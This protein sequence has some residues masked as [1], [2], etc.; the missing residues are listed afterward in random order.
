MSAT[1]SIS[2][3]LLADVRVAMQLSIDFANTGKGVRHGNNAYTPHAFPAYVAAVAS[4]EAFVNETF[5]GSFCRATYPK[6]SLWDLE[7]G[8]LERMDLLLKIM[9]VPYFLFGTSL[10]RS[11]QPF[12]DFALLCKV[13]N[14]VVHFKMQFEVPKY[15]GPLSDRGIALTT[16][17]I[18]GDYP[19]PARISCTEGIRWAHNTACRTAQALGSFIPGKERPHVA[20]TLDNFQELSEAQAYADLKPKVANGA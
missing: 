19:W 14:E 17:D 9:V 20:M 3:S 12:Q 16:G 13:R 5:L 15:I 18:K 6:A 4:I 11:E 2:G 8:A 1:M 7:R 10:K